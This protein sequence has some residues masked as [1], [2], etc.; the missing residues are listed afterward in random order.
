LTPYQYFLKEKC[1]MNKNVTIA[2]PRVRSWKFVLSCVVVL[3]LIGTKVYAQ[4]AA[5]YSFSAFTT[6][7]TTVSGNPTNILADDQTQTGIP[8][9]FTFNFAGTNYST[10]AMCSNGFMSLNNSPSNAN[11]NDAATAAGIGPMLMPL[12]D[13]LSG[14]TGTPAPTSYYATTG[15]SPNRIFSLECHGWWWTYQ[16]TSN[17]IS[18]EIKLYETSNMIDYV[19]EQE[20]QGLTNPTATIGIFN[21]G[22][23]YQTLP[24]AT[25]NPIPSNNTFTTSINTKPATG[26]GYRWTPQ[27]ILCTTPANNYCG[28][29]TVNVTYTAY[30]ITFN[31][32]NVFTAQ[33]SDNAGS[34]ATPTNIGTLTS[35]ASSGT[36]VCTIPAATGTGSGYRIRVISSNTAFTGVPNTNGNLTIN[37]LLVPT[38][39]IS[40]NP[41]NNICAGTSVTF[42]ALPQFGGTPSYQWF[43]NATPV[44]T[45]SPTYTSTTLANGDQVKVVMTSNATCALP[46]VVTSNIITMTVNP[47][48]TPT[49]TVTS[50]PAAANVCSGQSVTFTATVTNQGPTPVYQWYKNGNP[51]GTNSTTYTDNLLVNGDVITC[52]LTSNAPCLVVNPV[53]SAPLTITVTPTVAPTVSISANPGNIVCAGS[54]TTFTATPVNGGPTPSYQ[55]YVGATPVGGNSPT[56]STTTLVTG[57]VVSCVMTS[58]APC[59]VPT[60]ATSN[61]ITMTV[62]PVVVPTISMSTN[63]GT[64][65]CAGT[66]TTFSATIT[67]GGP[68]PTYAWTING[69]PVGA[70][71][72]TFTS[73][74]LNNGD[75]VM[76]TMTSSASCPSPASVNSSVTMTVNPVVVPS[77]SISASPGN[78]ICAGSMTTFTATPTNGG[79]T[80]SYQWYKNG[81]PV[82]TNSATY[83]DNTLATGDVL[84]CVMTSSASCPTPATATSNDITMTVNPVLPASV[85]IS[86]NTGPTICAGTDVTFLAT[87]VNG[88][89]VPTYQWYVNGNPVGTN[90]ASYQSATL[91]NGDVVKVAM[92]SSAVC[93][94][95]ITA[96]SSS[97]TMTV[98]PLSFPSV[99]ASVSPGTSICSGT[100]ATFTAVPT[101]GGPTPTYQWYKN[102]IPVAT[103]G[104][105]IDNGLNNTDVV[106]CSMTS[107]AICPT[108][109]VTS[110]NNLLMTV[111]TN[112]V[113]TVQVNGNPVVCS[114]SMASFSTQITNGGITPAYQWYV[115]GNPVVGAILPTYSSNG[116]TNGDIVSCDMT[117]SLTCATPQVV[118]NAVTMTVNPVVVPTISISSAPSDTICHGDMLTFTAVSTNGGPT[119]VYVWRKNGNPVGGPTDTYT[120]NTLIDSD[121]ITCDIMSSDPCPS[122]PLVG[123]N[124][125]TITVNEWITPKTFLDADPSVIMCSGSPIT[126]NATVDSA[127]PANVQSYQWMLNGNPVGTNSTSWTGNL[128]NNGDKVYYIM[129]S[130][131]PCLTKTVDTSKTDTVA[132]FVSGYLAGT[133]GNTETNVV[134]LVNQNVNTK[135]TYTDC[136]DICGV[137]PSGAS[138]VLG[139]TT[140]KV[141]LD[142]QVNS[143]NGMP[144]L[145]R[146][147]DIEPQNN[148]STSTA[149]I[150]L[151]AYENEFIAYNNV[152]ASQWLPMLPTNHVDNGNVRVTI[153]HG[154]GTTPGSYPGPVEEVIP[155][156]SWDIADN[157]WVMRFP[158]TGFSGYYIHTGQFPLDVKQV[159]SADPFSMMA[160]PNPVQDKVQVQ[161][162]GRMDKNATLVVTDLTG[163][164][165]INVPMD[166]AR[167]LIDMS[168]LASGMYMLKY[169]DD[170]RTQTVKITKQ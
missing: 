151:Y 108:P 60:T 106:Y 30:A 136:D 121:V 113:P 44:G 76:C 125:H 89:P 103:G 59:A 135:I 157:W 101:N 94:N 116:L 155:Q 14:A 55:W 23:D 7:Y 140:F 12:W 93:P 77:N 102:N 141:T 9:G 31:P 16:G 124:S 143:F 91:S 112:L 65:I 161:L 115:N 122:A 70:N 167:A 6:P 134:N 100:A 90:S 130:T 107:S 144:Y 131:A 165:L 10:V 20:A 169:S 88:G 1:L 57:N 156:V 13:D 126:F 39:T 138:P 2:L 17:A 38:V 32:G 117:S 74:T 120:D 110:S 75:V 25:A 69:N 153:F 54:T 170:A 46:T 99:S 128:L 87:A 164:V 127:G 58:N 142:P 78:N 24:N 81:N 80:P 79:P 40:A 45:N 114:G 150:E 149:V 118:N 158:T 132:W 33:L 86:N 36:I 73:N 147:Y 34:F 43:V 3:L 129:T 62:N 47:M 84:N 63:P 21:T 27:M 152:A 146:H 26:Q 18:F 85:S 133:V 8:L 139:I 119:P 66:N 98:N 92:T 4:P 160:Y 48:I 104:T 109:P 37:P 137:N 97:I 15:V 148:P 64:T 96:V 61:S 111:T 42:T 52:K 35:T 123:S 168:A 163:K 53:T 72:S 159:N 22:T 145:Q 41:G 49:I 29:N 50:V 83:N 51:V 19:Y 105:Y 11:S 162:T 95:P 82:G 154:N 68:T 166:N 67:N 5:Y 56:Y 71:Q 28:G